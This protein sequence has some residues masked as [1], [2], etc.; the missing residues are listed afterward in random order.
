MTSRC[1]QLRALAIRLH[2]DCRYEFLR[3]PYRCS[4]RGQSADDRG[5]C[6]GD[7]FSGDT[8]PR[9]VAALDRLANGWRELDDAGGDGEG[10]LS[11]L[12]RRRRVYVT[13]GGNAFARLRP[14]MQPAGNY[15][16]A[17][18]G[19]G[20]GRGQQPE[21][22]RGL[23][24]R[25]M[26]RAPRLTGRLRRGRYARYD[27][28][29]GDLFS[30]A[31]RRC[32]SSPCVARASSP[33]SPSAA[34]WRP[35]PR[36]PADKCSGTLAAAE[37]TFRI[38]PWAVGSRESPRRAGAHA[39]TRSRARV[40]RRVDYQRSADSSSASTISSS[41]L[42]GVH[43]A[44]RPGFAAGH[45]CFVATAG[46]VEAD[47]W[48]FRLSNMSNPRL[49]GSIDYS[50]TRARWQGSWRFREGAALLDDGRSPGVPK[51]RIST[52]SLP[53]SRPTFRGNGDAAWSWS[54]KSTPATRGWIRRSRGLDWTRGS[55]FSSNQALAL[56]FCGHPLGDPWSAF[57]TY[58]ATPPIL[59]RST[60]S[61]SS[62]AR[63][64]ELSA[65]SWSASQGI[66]ADGRASVFLDPDSS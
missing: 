57:E 32:P 9:G 31:P 21:C 12:E 11:S 41:T 20:G 55:T 28:Q 65:A 10:D 34:W 50:V 1:G 38:A 59:R 18:R 8:V 30:P 64:S 24:V 60:T 37:R 40:Q 23:R 53:R 13:P 51:P 6:P 33:Q 15:T 16:R 17:T 58:S 25:Q 46:G 7:L 66:A 42:F 22:R 48:A 52:T 36:V 26:D 45:Y 27:H 43:L 2:G 44:R 5:F 61:S 19:A 14:D 4:R 62:S 49:R 63:R 29:R 56:R 3:R 39:R 54:T 35:A 47:G